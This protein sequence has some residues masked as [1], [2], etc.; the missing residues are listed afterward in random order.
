MKN[1]PYRIA[2]HVPVDLPVPQR[3]GLRVYY[4]RR[5]FLRR[6]GHQ[7]VSRQRLCAWA[8]LLA[9]IFSGVAAAQPPEHWIASGQQALQR[10][11][12]D[13][14]SSKGMRAKNLILFVGD[15]MG[16]STVNAARILA[17]QRAGGQGEE[18]LL[19]FEKFP[20]L[21]LVK[22]YTTDSQVPDSA[23]TMSAIMTGVKTRS[24]VIS[25][26]EAATWKDCGVDSDHS[27]RTLLE[28]SEMAG[29]S[30]GVVSTARVTHAT[31][32][33]TYAHVPRRGWEADVDVSKRA[34]AKRCR[35]I[36]RQLLEFSFGNGL[37]VV[38]GGGRS[39]FL[40][41]EVIDPEYGSRNG[42]R[43][44]GL[45]LTE[46]W[47]KSRRNAAYIWNLEQFKAVDS[48]LVSRLLGLFEPSHMQY[49][50]D[51]D[52]DAAGE[53]SLAEM[54]AL[55]IAILA[56]NPAGFF[57]MVEGG[58]IDHAH[59]AGNAYRALT[60]AIAFAQ[61]VATAE[62][63][64]GGDTLIVVTADH[65]HTLTIGGY[66]KR[67]NPILGKVAEHQDGKLVYDED[68]LGLPYTTLTYAN[69]PGHHAV[70]RAARAE[71]VEELLFRPP[72][73][74]QVDTEAPN[75]LQSSAVPRSSETHGGTDVPV[76]ARGPGAQWFRGVIE[77]NVL[78]WLMAQAMGFVEGPTSPPPAV[79]EKR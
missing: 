31:P 56:R 68:A 36:A 16:L 27:I 15:G 11:L 64:T 35:D 37:E 22:T 65:D 45:D 51:R 7:I 72:D 9:G 8:V 49:E 62:R 40:P 29:L 25:M 12:A 59:H 42:R 18:N 70:A 75:Y 34:R 2:V 13:G 4:P 58:R 30:T 50:A 48:R 76:Y 71:G 5:S 69:G 46:A 10:A 47:R 77:Q 3:L 54:T 19:S 1:S 39:R 63:L 66:P 43:E 6:A 14:S 78:Y 41:T 67:G 38:L 55:A 21:A 24:G 17:G 73:L 57:L 33:A 52:R 26:S 28:R 79:T 60:D 74:S 32:A 44:D 53:P 61:A 23:G 20:H